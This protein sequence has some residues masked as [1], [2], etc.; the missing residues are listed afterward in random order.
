[1]LYPLTFPQVFGA[2]IDY[3]DHRKLMGILSAALL[4]AIQGVQIATVEVSSEIVFSPLS[5]PP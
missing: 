3:T 4:T 1:M 5:D 2:I